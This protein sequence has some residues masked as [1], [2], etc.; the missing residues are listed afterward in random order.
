MGAL[1]LIT[2]YGAMF[3]LYHTPGLASP[4]SGFLLG[5]RCST[6]LQTPV[7]HTLVYYGLVSRSS[8]LEPA[9]SRFMIGERDR[10]TI[11][12]GTHREPSSGQ[13][14]VLGLPG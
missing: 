14:L 8:G 9:G 13:I 11:F 10:S 3:G 6:S 1:S 4:G 2:P 12:T 5:R 7:Y